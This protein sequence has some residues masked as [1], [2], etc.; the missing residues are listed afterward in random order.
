MRAAPGA[1]LDDLDLVDRRRHLEKF[2][3]VVQPR[4]PAVLDRV[5]RFRENDFAAPVMVA[6][7]LSV[8]RDVNELRAFSLPEER[9]E[10]LRQPR[11]TVS[12]KAEGDRLGERTVVEKDRDVPP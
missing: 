6:I 4:A 12:E 1:C 5:E 10:S 2:A 11:R 3:V 8:G 7:G 9:G